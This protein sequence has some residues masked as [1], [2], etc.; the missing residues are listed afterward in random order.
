MR[1]WHNLRRRT[2]LSGIANLQRYGNM[3]LQHTDLRNF[4][5]MPGL[6]YL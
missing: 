5:H 4:H 2:Q 6:F 3:R 1:R